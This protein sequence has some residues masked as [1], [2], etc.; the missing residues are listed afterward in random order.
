MTEI[1]SV[2]EIIKL[3]FYWSLS[4]VGLN[5]YSGTNLNCITLHY[6]GVK[7]LTSLLS[8]KDA[9]RWCHCGKWIDPDGAKLNLYQLF[10]TQK[11]WDRS[12]LKPFAW[13]VFHMTRHNSLSKCSLIV[14][15][16]F[17]WS[18]YSQK[19]PRSRTHPNIC[20]DTPKVPYR[21][22]VILDFYWSNPQTF[23]KIYYRLVNE[24]LDDFTVTS[25]LVT[26][27]GDE[28]CWWQL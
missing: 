1:V 13:D 19:K 27:V 15:R 11:S 21:V 26:D 17:K 4:S 5:G 12:A 9:T 16:R 23:E 2:F 28:M 10:L 22:T 6:R 18:E 8:V 24:V 3:S 20:M 14:E 7:D 25:M